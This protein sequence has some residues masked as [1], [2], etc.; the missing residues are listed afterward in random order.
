VGIATG[1]TQNNG[2]PEVMLL[3]TNRLDIDA[4][5]VALAYRY[6]WAVEIY[7]SCNLR[8]T[9]FWHKFDSVDL[10]TARRAVCGGEA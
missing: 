9:L 7:Q 5:L 10:H 3:V 1:K 6:R 4:D 8:R 2:A